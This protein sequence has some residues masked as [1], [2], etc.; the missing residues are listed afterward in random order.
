[1]TSQ[2]SRTGQINDPR[3]LILSLRNIN[4]FGKDLFRCSHYEFEDIIRTIDFA[5][6]F[7]PKLE[8]S[9][10]RYRLTGQLATRAPVIL[11]PGITKLM[12]KSRYDILFTICGFPQDLLVV[13]TIGD[14]RSICK[15]SVCLIDEFWLTQ[16]VKYRHYFRILSKFDV[17]MLYYSKTVKPLSEQIDSRCVFLPPGID[18]I[19]FS[20]YPNPP[21]RVVDVYSIG[22]RS[23]VTHQRL[24]RMVQESDLF[25]LH[26]SIGGH[27][28]INSK[29]HRTL[30]ANIAKRSR[31][32]LVNPG[33]MDLPDVRGNQIEV[34][35]RY[36]EGAAS[37][38]IMIGERPTNEVFEKLFDWPEAVIQLPYDSGRIDRIIKDLDGDPTRQDSIR[39]ANVIHILKHHDW[40]YRWETVLNAVGLEPMQGLLQRKERLW[41]LAE[42]VSQDGQISSVA[43]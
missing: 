23:E 19:L 42:V 2:I 26:D 8:S 32:F 27:L 25:Y 20:P 1:M 9:N 22:R 33:K 4:I 28:A 18:A 37:G 24:L 31:Y 11:K 7:A 14:L 5:E 29:E 43:G 38:T 17:V 41:K 40:V 21:E 15:K 30:F 10:I 35:N 16:L 13:N 3:V 12:S 34:S 6:L 39:R 36:F